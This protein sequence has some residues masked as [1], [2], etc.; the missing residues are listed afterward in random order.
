MASALYMA[1]DEGVGLVLLYNGQ[2]VVYELLHKGEAIGEAA[3]ARLLGEPSGGTLQ[4][5][6]PA[7]TAAVLLMIAL[8][9]RSLVRAVR[10]ARRGEPAVRPAFGSRTVGLAV[11]AWG[12]VLAP[13]LILSGTPDMLGAPWPI[14]IQIDLGQAL[15]TYSILQAV[16]GV[17]SMTPVGVRLAKRIHGGASGI[18]AASWRRLAR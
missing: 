6:Y 9:L 1:P 13:A 3:M 2:S 17:V 15:A 8:Q 10:R 12:W 7:F 11:A 18:G 14:L 4:A 5:L 16:I